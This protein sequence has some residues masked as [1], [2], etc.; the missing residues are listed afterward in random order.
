MVY[1]MDFILEFIKEYILYIMLWFALINAASFII[2]GLDKHYAECGLPRVRE[3]TLM[4]F[5]ALGGA[6]MMYFGMLLFRHKT[7][8]PKFSVGVPLII[9]AYALLIFWLEAKYSLVTEL[10]RLYQNQN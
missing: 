8:K 9:L 5:S 7:M 10:I 3:R 2:C 1:N 6:F 4:L